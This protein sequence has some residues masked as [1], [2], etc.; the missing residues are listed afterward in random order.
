MT[1]VR[2]V[3]LSAICGGLVVLAFGGCG[4]KAFEGSGAGAM[5]GTGGAGAQSGSAGNGGGGD[6]GN[7]G[8]AGNGGGGNAGIGG[9]GNAGI[10]GNAGTG[11]GGAGAAG[12]G[13]FGGGSGGAAGTAGTGGLPPEWQ[14]CSDTSQC[15][16]RENTCCQGCGPQEVNRALAFNRTYSDAVNRSVCGPIPP[17]CPAVACAP[18]PAWVLPFCIEGRCQAIDIRSDKLTS[19]GT[20]AQCRL[21]WGTT[22]CESCGTPPQQMLVAVNSQVNYDATVCGSGTGC[23]DCLTSPYPMDARAMCRTDTHR[24]EVVW[25]LRD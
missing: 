19:C 22:C 25:I 11:G 14:S 18:T 24:C 3:L 13:G 17:P 10:G 9:G 4:G 15:V 23:P 1:F 6:A 7:G 8:N 21:R 12:S 5:A 2:P 20:D 16:V